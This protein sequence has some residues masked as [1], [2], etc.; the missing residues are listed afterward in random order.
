MG[1]GGVAHAACIKA[2][3]ILERIRLG[4]LHVHLAC[5]PH[6]ITQLTQVMGHA[7]YR[8]STC[9]VV[10]RA[11]VAH[12]VLTGEQ[13]RTA[14]LAHCL[15]KISAIEREAL[16]RQ[17]VDVWRPCILP[18]VQGQVV[19]RAIIGHDDENIGLPGRV[20]REPGERK[21]QDDQW[22]D[23]LVHKIILL[24]GAHAGRPLSE[25]AP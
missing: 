11:A 5:N 24:N 13:F 3:H 6:A 12:R 23:F 16:R 15:T 10:P 18:T 4:R 20:R 17:S 19:V 22:N 14:R 7:R 25:S 2:R 9:R 8:C 1:L 21:A